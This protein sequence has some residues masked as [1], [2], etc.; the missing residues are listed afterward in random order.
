MRINIVRS[1]CLFDVVVYLTKKTINPRHIIWL[2][3]VTEGRE[4]LAYINQN[5]KTNRFMLI[6]S[7]VNCHQ[8]HVSIVSLVDGEFIKYSWGVESMSDAVT[9]LFCQF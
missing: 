7:T 4:C 8:S 6:D 3:L 9:L 5:Q 1:V 2:K